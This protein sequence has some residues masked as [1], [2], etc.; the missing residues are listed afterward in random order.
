MV[1]TRSYKMVYKT[2]KGELM[3][4]TFAAIDVGITDEE[5]HLL[6]HEADNCYVTRVVRGD[7][8]INDSK[9]I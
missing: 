8:I 3:D 2:N 6:I 5:R 4:F 7:W 9:I 1:G